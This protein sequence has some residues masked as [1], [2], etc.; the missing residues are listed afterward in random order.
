MAFSYWFVMLI[1]PSSS[2]FWLPNSNL[3]SFFFASWI[4]KKQMHC[5]VMWLEEWL[6]SM[7]HYCL[8]KLDVIPDKLDVMVASISHCQQPAH[9][10]GS[11]GRERS[12]LNS[13]AIL[14]WRH[15]LIAK[16]EKIVRKHNPT[17]WQ[18]RTWM[19]YMQAQGMSTTVWRPTRWVQA[20]VC[21]R[22]PSSISQ[23]TIHF[24]VE[25]DKS[26]LRAYWLTG[27][28]ACELTS[29]LDF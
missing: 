3:P 25:K 26:S 13:V 10:F 1:M 20:I 27:I 17:C 7:Q 14:A 21:T 2:S 28:L 19:L 29:F 12:C 11:V 18:T 4:I 23:T 16:Y 24:Q 9:T 8:S 6:L 5:I 15:W 22:S